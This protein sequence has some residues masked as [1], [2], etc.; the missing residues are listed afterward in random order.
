MKTFIINPR[1]DPEL[2]KELENAR[3][4][5]TKY[6]DCYVTRYYEYTTAGQMIGTFTLREPD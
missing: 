5:G 3:K 4:S 1:M 2:F 6:E